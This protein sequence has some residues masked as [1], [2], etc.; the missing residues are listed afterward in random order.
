MAS[1][2]RKKKSLQAVGSILTKMPGKVGQVSTS[3]LTQAVGHGSTAS[4]ITIKKE[5]GKRATN[6]T[7]DTSHSFRTKRK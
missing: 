3:T 1:K 5:L 7:Y 4:D 2:V 6:D